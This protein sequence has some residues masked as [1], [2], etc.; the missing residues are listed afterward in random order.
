[1][2]GVYEKRLRILERTERM[3]RPNLPEIRAMMGE[4]KVQTQKVS[5][6]RPVMNVAGLFSLMKKL[7]MGLS[8]GLRN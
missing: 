4:K 7:L 6:E 5:R 1:M 3:L 2:G 8:D